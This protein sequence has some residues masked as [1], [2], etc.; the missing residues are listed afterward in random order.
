M[1]NITPFCKSEDTH[2]LDN[3]CVGEPHRDEI[4]FYTLQHTRS[5]CRLYS[6]TAAALS[7]HQQ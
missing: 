6:V 3:T 7:H 4:C 1:K 2:N 5:H